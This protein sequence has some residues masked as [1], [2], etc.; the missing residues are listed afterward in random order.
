VVI[1]LAHQDARSIIER[2]RVGR[3]GC[4]FNGEPYVVP[5]NYVFD[6]D[7]IYI[8]SRAGRKVDALR[9]NPRACLLV[10]EIHDEFTWRSA[11]AFGDYEEIGDE[12]ERDLV[13]E[14]F[15]KRFRSLTP[16]ESVANRPESDPIVFRI[17]VDTITGAGEGEEATTIGYSIN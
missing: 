16:V 6:R 11:L 13:I 3:L 17:R 7:N 15:T 8:H 14:L 2:G 4:V 9:A 1:K 12:A 10:D 5:V